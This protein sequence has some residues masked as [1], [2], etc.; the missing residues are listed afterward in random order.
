M[1]KVGRNE[2]CPCGSEQKYKKC[3]LPQ[4]KTQRL[5]NNAKQNVINKAINFS[6]KFRSET[7]ELKKDYRKL[8]NYGHSRELAQGEAANLTNIILFDYPIKENQTLIKLFAEKYS[9]QLNRR[10]KR[11][12]KRLIDLNL[13]VYEVKK[14]DK[15]GYHLKDLWE[16]ETFIV[17]K[18]DTLTE[19]A[20]EHDIL[21]TRIAKIK[22]TYQIIGT[23]GKV[24]NDLKE[25]V[26]NIINYLQTAYE[27]TNKTSYWNKF[28]QEYSLF[29]SLIPSKI[30]QLKLR[31]NDDN[32]DQK[33][34]ELVQDHLSLD[35]ITEELIS[36][37][38]SNLH[39]SLLELKNRFKITLD[40]NIEP[41]DKIE[42]IATEKMK[43]K[44]TLPE[45]NVSLE[46]WRKFKEKSDSI[47]GNATS[48]AAGLEYLVNRLVDLNLTQGDVGKRY[49]VSA[50]TVAR[51]YKKI[52]KQLKI[53][54]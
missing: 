52:N 16:N 54:L 45:V 4:E 40:D 39:N 50:S 24:V 33:I 29:I 43:Q 5:Y 6:E 46:L 14:I 20:N 3:C 32:Y 44:L 31:Q 41:T 47:R 11:V 35:N 2:P 49:E 48:W 34:I 38:E 19:M 10:E 28:I 9:N 23:L 26:I 12:L 22:N 42:K 21:F 7:R 13:G 27:S 37:E 30:Q 18:T 8:M 15:E 53:E 25:Q 51:T 36:T 1:S 17:S